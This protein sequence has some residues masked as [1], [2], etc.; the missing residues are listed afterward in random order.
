M[1]LGFSP[2]AGDALSNAAGSAVVPIYTASGIAPSVSFGT[3]SAS[4]PASIAGFSSTQ[5]GT[6]T[7]VSAGVYVAAGIA[8]TTAFGTPSTPTTAFT[9]TGVQSTYIRTTRF[10]KPSRVLQNYAPSALCG[11]RFGTPKA[12]TTHFTCVAAGISNIALFGQA[13]ALAVVHGKTGAIGASKVGTPVGLFTQFGF[14]SGIKSTH[15]GQP[16]V[17]A[18]PC[19]LSL[20]IIKRDIH[21]YVRAE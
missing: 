15:F 4:A 5:F 10:G 8:P 11:V 7:A 2:L 14:V 21:R 3:P 19:D 20:H 6:P 17:P 12:V 13:S 16:R 18:K 1:S 9:V